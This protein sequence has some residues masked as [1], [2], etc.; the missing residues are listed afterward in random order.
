MDIRS[1][2]TNFQHITGEL[3]EAADSDDFEKIN[4][5]LAKRQ[6]LINRISESRFDRKLFKDIC[7][8]MKLLELEKKLSEKL[9]LKREQVKEKIDNISNSYRISS[10]YN[11]ILSKSIFL[12]RRV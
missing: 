7:I 4:M 10:S 1:E 6:E 12:S 3:I 2:L 8:Q 5:L 9:S 11:K